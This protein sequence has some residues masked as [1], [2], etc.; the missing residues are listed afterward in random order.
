MYQQTDCVNRNQATADGEAESRCQAHF[1]ICI[2]D[3]QHDLSNLQ[4]VQQVSS[5][6]DFELAH[7]DVAQRLV[8]KSEGQAEE[9]T[10]EE[11]V[12]SHAS[13]VDPLEPP[14]HPYGSKG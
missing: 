13:S 6:Q 9:I 8:A 7:Q 5:T 14:S 1:G 10:C 11:V 4:Q 2:W 3:G 12:V